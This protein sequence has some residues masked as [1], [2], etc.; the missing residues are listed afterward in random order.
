MWHIQHGSESVIYAVD[1]NQVRENVLTGAAWLGSSSAPGSEVVPELRQPSALICSSKGCDSL[2]SEGGLTS[3]DELLIKHVRTT[4]EEGG[5]VLIPCDSSARVL[6]V[7][8]L[9]ERVWDEDDTLRKCPLYMASNTSG[10]TMRYARSML[11]WMDERVVREFESKASLRV[12]GDRNNAS[13]FNFKHMKLIERKTQLSRALANDSAKVFIASDTSLTWGYSKDILESICGDEKNLLVLPDN[14]AS[15]SRANMPKPPRSGSSL[16]SAIAKKLNDETAQQ[17]DEVVSASKVQIIALG[18]NELPAYQQYLARQRQRQ[19]GIAVDKETALET[20]ADVL[21]DR[22][23]STSSSDASDDELQGKALNTFA[24]LTHTKQKLGATDEEL[25]INILLRRKDIH[26]YDVRGKRGRERVFP[27]VVKRRRADDFGDVIRAEEYLR[28]EE[29]IDANEQT[30]ADEA[31][32]GDASVGQKRRFG[33]QTDLHGPDSSAKRRKAGSGRAV[34]EDDANR[35]GAVEDQYAEDDSDE[36]EY[37]PEEAAILGP[38]KVVLHKHEVHFKLRAVAV[39]FSGLHE[40]RSLHMLLPLIKPRKLIL[41]AGTASETAKL[42]A[43]CERLLVTNS[44]QQGAKRGSEIFAPSVGESVDASVDTDAWTIKLSPALVRT[45]HWQ[46]FRDL[47]LV[48]INGK[49]DRGKK[50]DIDESNSTSKR[51]KTNGQEPSK[52]DASSATS[53]NISEDNLP[54]LQAMAAGFMAT[55]RSL[56]ESVHV[57]DL[58]LFELRNV[59]RALNHSA[60]FRG[61]GV[62]LVD[63][64]ITVR[65]DGIGRIEVEGGG[66]TILGHHASSFNAVKQRIYEGL[67]VVSAR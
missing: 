42:K 38:R 36:S 32:R 49:V 35:S 9:L 47:D 55:A 29:R 14:I 22:S 25:G 7:A 66:G 65:K 15:I 37:E 43:D 34:N 8:Y 1:W 16:L 19:N 18:S 56:T 28:A 5:T 52:R 31:G 51:L 10:A 24:S 40:Q 59:L 67:A 23:S 41:T 39:D 20:S 4:V 30:F 17:L 50:E 61:E 45:L 12:Q 54:M 11:E 6:E 13:P 27:Y 21:D 57:G 2:G 26:D 63:G 58:R 3:R 53:G 60:E 64:Y 46:H 33:T 44:E 48:T 62:L